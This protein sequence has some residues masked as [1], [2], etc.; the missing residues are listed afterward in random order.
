MDGAIAGRRIDGKLGEEHVGL[1]SADEVRAR[2][3]KARRYAVRLVDPRA[4]HLRQ[5][6]QRRRVALGPD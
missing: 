1:V 6:L 3:D 4:A 2:A 5:G